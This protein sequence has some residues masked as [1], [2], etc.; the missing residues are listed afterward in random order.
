LGGWGLFLAKSAADEITFNRKGNVVFLTKYLRPGGLTAVLER[1]AAPRPDAAAP[2]G[3]HRRHTKMLRKTTRLLRKHD[4]RFDSSRKAA[5][6][7]PA[8]D[9]SQTAE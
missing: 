7:G 4:P 8:E 9:R 3:T 1:A 6:A 2:A 5:G